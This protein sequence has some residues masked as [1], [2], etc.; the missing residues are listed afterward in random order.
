MKTTIGIFKGKAKDNNK[1]LLETLYNVG[2]L[3]AWGLTREATKYQRIGGGR[4]S[5]H[6]IFNK[7]LRDLEKKGYIKKVEK[8]WI[9]QF[10]GIIAVLIIQS[11]PKPWNEKWTNIFENYVKPLNEVPG[12]YAF[13]EDE[14]EILSL[15][16]VVKKTPLIIKELERWVALSIY[17]KELMQKGLINLD[18]IKNES[19]LSLILTELMLDF[20]KKGV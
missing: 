12:K 7:R 2:P 8:K 4:H 13:T 9:L 3:S 16:D 10:K 20:S 14:K 15:D 19:L 18:I 17:I 11:E 5:L 1:F 6:A